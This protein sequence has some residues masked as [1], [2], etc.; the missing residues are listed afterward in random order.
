MLLRGAVPLK[1]SYRPC[2]DLRTRNLFCTMQCVSFPV[3]TLCHE[4]QGYLLN[5][6]ILQKRTLFTLICC[7]GL[8]VCI[9]NEDAEC[10]NA[11]N[12]AQTRAILCNQARFQKVSFFMFF[13]PKVWAQRNWIGAL[14]INRRFLFEPTHF[15]HGLAKETQAEKGSCFKIRVTYIICTITGPHIPTCGLMT[16]VV[17]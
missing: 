4:T 12:S 6:Q 8:Y 10:K 3:R 14:L 17:Q 1:I 11:C 2:V 7:V 9:S 13:S 16:M 5:K 15:F